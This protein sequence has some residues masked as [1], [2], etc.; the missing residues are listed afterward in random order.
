[1]AADPALLERAIANIVNNAVR[2]NPEGGRVRVEAASATATSI[3]ASSTVAAASP[4]PTASRGFQPFQRL[5]DSEPGG[6]GLGLAVAHGFLDGDGSD[7]RDRR[8][9]RRRRHGDD[10]PA[11]GGLVSRILVVDDEQPILRAMA[12]NLRA[13]QYDVDVAAT[14]EEALDAR[15]PPSP[16]PRRPRPRP[17]GIGGL[18]VIRG[19]RGWTSV[20]IVVLSARGDRANKVAALD[21]GADDY[22]SKPFDMEELLARLRA[23][24]RRG[25]SS[26]TEE[27]PTIDTADFTV[28]LGAQHSWRRA[29]RSA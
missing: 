20:P 16:R 18:D 10:R 24:L 14:G 12:V 4:R 21:A 6:I 3:C 25:A 1:M 29:G 2:F 13:R 8:H 27:A 19:L 23:A 22:V 15:R 26:S 5:G 7:D 11:G 28:D 9:A 17:P